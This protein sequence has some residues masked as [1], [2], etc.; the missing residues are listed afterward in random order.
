MDLL[1][2]I[3]RHERNKIILL[4]LR[5]MCHS[6]YYARSENQD[7]TKGK[8]LNLTLILDF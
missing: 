3:L 1:F 8:D 4:P 5:K 7:L 6:R 2:S